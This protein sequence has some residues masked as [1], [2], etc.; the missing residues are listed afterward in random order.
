MKRLRIAK[1]ANIET[2]CAVIEPTSASKGSGASGG[3]KPARAVARRARTGSA[4]AAKRENP[5]MA[6]SGPNARNRSVD[7]PKSYGS[8]S[9]TRATNGH[10]TRRHS[11]HWRTGE[12]N[13]RLRRRDRDPRVRRGGTGRREVGGQ[14]QEPD[15]GP[16]Q[17]AE[18]EGH[19][20]AEAGEDAR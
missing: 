2:C 11:D 8:G 5:A 14:G 13:P 12:E 10:A 16:V 18:Q 1:A 6:R 15:S 9:F 4:S 20:V 17:G 3:R 19:D 7:S